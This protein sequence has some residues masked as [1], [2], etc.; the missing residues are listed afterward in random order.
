MIPM[1]ASYVRRLPLN[2]RARTN[3]AAQIS[4]AGL[5]LSV[6]ISFREL[7]AWFTIGPRVR[8]ITVGGLGTG[9]Y[10][11]EKIPPAVAP[12]AGHQAAFVLLVILVDRI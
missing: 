9:L 5:S 3:E 7:V 4:Q 6:W 8:R 2:S 12:H 10:Y 11:T 1:T